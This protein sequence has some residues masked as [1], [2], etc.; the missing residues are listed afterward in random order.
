MKILQVGQASVPLRSN[1]LS[2]PSP[3]QYEEKDKAFKEQLA[4]L[5]SLLPTLQVRVEGSVGLDTPA[6]GPSPEHGILLQVHLV[7]CSSF[8]SLASKAE[9]LDLGYVSVPSSFRTLSS[10]LESVLYRRSLSHITAEV[11]W[12]GELSLPA[13]PPRCYLLVTPTPHPTLVLSSSP[14][15]GAD[16]EAARRR[17]AAAPPKT[18]SEQ[19]GVPAPSLES[20]V[21]GLGPEIPRQWKVAHDPISGPDRQRSPRRICALSGAAAAAGA[22]QSRVH[23]GRRQHVS[24]G[25]AGSRKRLSHH[26]SLLS[27]S[28]ATV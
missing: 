13:P 9:F 26:P 8:L 7:I 20:G 11:T 14:M 25:R 18:S 17:H 12:G 19:Q 4:H 23:R 22:P 2:C 24:R 16:G 21:G 27:R 1:S 5:A 15:T 3:S 10:H 28:P 6:H